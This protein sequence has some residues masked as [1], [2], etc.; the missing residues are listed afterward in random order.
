[1]SKFYV[2]QRVRLIADASG[3]LGFLVGRLATVTSGLRYPHFEHSFHQGELVHGI[4]VDDWPSDN[5]I[6]PPR[7]LEPLDDDSRSLTTWDHE[8]FKNLGWKP[9]TVRA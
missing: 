5:V 8:T 6:A 1:M 7:E 2:G 4:K 3:T 9:G